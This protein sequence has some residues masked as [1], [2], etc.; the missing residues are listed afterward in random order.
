MGGYA[1]EDILGRKDM[2]SQFRQQFTG[3][4]DLDLAAQP[5]GCRPR[6]TNPKQVPAFLNIQR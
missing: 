4:Q 3:W 1:H 2:D 6:Q 5:A